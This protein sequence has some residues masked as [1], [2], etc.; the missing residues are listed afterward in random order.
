ML[1]YF[2]TPFHFHRKKKE[3]ELLPFSLDIYNVWSTTSSF[4]HNTQSVWEFANNNVWKTEETFF[5]R[6]KI[7]QEL[8][9]SHKIIYRFFS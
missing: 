8:S 7:F 5:I 2:Y 4:I 1:N 6:V 9:Q 3:K